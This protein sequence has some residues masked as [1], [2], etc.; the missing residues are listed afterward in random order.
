MSPPLHS[1]SGRRD[2][3]V[4]PPRPPLPSVPNSGR[5]Q[6]AVSLTYEAPVTD[7]VQLGR[8]PANHISSEGGT[9]ETVT[10]RPDLPKWAGTEEGHSVP[11]MADNPVR[12]A[13]GQPKM[14]E[15]S[16]TLL[17][18]PA[19]RLPTISKWAG[20]GGVA[21]AVV[22]TVAGFVCAV[23]V[24]GALVGVGVAAAAGALLGYRE[25]LDDRVA[26]EWR[27]VPILDFELVGYE[28]TVSG[29]HDRETRQSSYVHDY[30]ARLKEENLG[31]YYEPAV[32]RY[33]EGESRL[34]V[35]GQTR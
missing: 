28:H 26:L 20:L 19:P 6:V 21:G 17:A 31:W 12:D 4:A 24:L 3:S 8:I 25:T 2:G 34:A 13:A 27:L 15:K 11:V 18:D 14:A 30:E 9:D 29:G 22:G 5:G 7:R 33:E 32:V 35:F 10:Y 16:V 1:L 23:P